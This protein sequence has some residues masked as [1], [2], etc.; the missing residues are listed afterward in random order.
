MNLTVVG[1]RKIYLNTQ[2]DL[3]HLETAMYF[4]NGTS[5]RI[6]TSD[7]DGDMAWQAD[8]NGRLPSWSNYFIEIGHNGNGAIE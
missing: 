5:F 8:I 7:L 4:P 1:K 2:V 3:I 6:R